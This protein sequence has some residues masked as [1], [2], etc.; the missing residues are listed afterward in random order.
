MPLASGSL[1]APHFTAGELGADDATASSAVLANLRTLADYLERARTV[2]GVPLRVTSGYR[3]PSHPLS[4]KEPNSDHPRGLAADVVPVGLSQYD[5][6]R[7]LS[8]ARDAGTLPAW[9]QLIFYP[10]EGHLHV[11]LGER[12]R[13]EVRVKVLTDE[14]GTFLAPLNSQLL[15]Q[16]RGYV[17]PLLTMLLVVLVGLFILHPEWLGK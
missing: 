13:G 16:L 7:K 9:D 5:A 2:L 10:L 1:L 6:W 4:V 12:R 3:P 15:T 17:P 11:G 8:A 14:G